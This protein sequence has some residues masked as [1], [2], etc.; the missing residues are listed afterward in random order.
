MGTKPAAS[1]TRH[2]EQTLGY[3]K[4]FKEHIADLVHV[5][6]DPFDYTEEIS[7]TSPLQ[8]VLQRSKHEGRNITCH[9]YKKTDKPGERNL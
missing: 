3:Q 1:E 7:W 5:T 4:R 8:I 6:K 9:A 2:H